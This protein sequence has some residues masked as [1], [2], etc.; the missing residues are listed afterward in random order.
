MYAAILVTGIIGYL[1]NKIAV[2]FEGKFIH[3]AGK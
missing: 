3:W 1:L 2:L